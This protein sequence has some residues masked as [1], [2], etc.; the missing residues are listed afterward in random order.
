[1]PADKLRFRFAKTGR[2]RLL[3]HHDLMRCFERLVRRADLPIQTT[4][5]F[6]PGPRIIFPLPLPLGIVGHQEVVEMEFRQPQQAHTALAALTSQAPPDLYL[7]QARPIPLQA[8][9]RVRRVEYRLPIPA[10]R[11]QALLP[12]MEHLLQGQAVWVPRLRPTPKYLNIRPYLRRLQLVW[13]PTPTH[14]LPAP[15]TL[16]PTALTPAVAANSPL[17]LLDFWVTQDGTARP[18]EVLR[19]LGVADL[20]DN[21]AVVER[22]VVELRDEV[23]VA[24]PADQPPDGPAQTRPLEAHSLAALVAAEKCRY[25]RDLPEQ[26]LPAH[27]VE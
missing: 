11:C 2:L 5:G 7:L 4:A 25:R 12:Q 9:A 22:T 1:M 17:L 13:E 8:V 20:L 10:Q 6:R 16:P 14:T 15:S 24:D 19:C 26:R 23:D 21:G 18:E 3:S 27:V